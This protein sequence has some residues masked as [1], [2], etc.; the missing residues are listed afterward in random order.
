[1]TDAKL[2]S[3]PGCAEMALYGC[4]LCYPGKPF[5][6]DHGTPG[7]DREA[8]WDV[9]LTGPAEVVF[10]GEWIEGV[11]TPDIASAGPAR[12][13]RGRDSCSKD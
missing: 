10:A 4:D 13:G 12:G 7:G 9:S 6:S 11:R 2:C 3:Y 5:C 8:G 1:M